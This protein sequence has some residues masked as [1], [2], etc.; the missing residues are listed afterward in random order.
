[1]Q[2][3]IETQQ[4]QKLELIQIKEFELAK[5]SFRNIRLM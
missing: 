4:A 3:Q 2:N 5:E 1:M